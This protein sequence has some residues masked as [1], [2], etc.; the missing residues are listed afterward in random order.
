MPITVEDTAYSVKGYKFEKSFEK[1]LGARKNI[2]TKKYHSL[3]VHR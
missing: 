1:K 2:F 3:N